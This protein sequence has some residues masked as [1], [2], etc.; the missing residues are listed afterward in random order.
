[1][2]EAGPVVLA[3]SGL[4]LLDSNQIREKTERGTISRYAELMAGGT[5]FP[6]IKVALTD[7]TDATK[8]YTLV[9][10]WHRVRAAQEIGL[11][12]IVAE[13]VTAQAHEVPWLAYEANRGHGLPLKLTRVERREIFRAY[14]QAKR[15][16]TG[17]G[18]AIKSANAM[19][20]DLVGIV[21][22]RSL[23]GWMASDF[24]AIYRA[25]N[26]GGLDP[27]EDQGGVKDRDMDAAYAKEARACLDNF[28]ACMR[29][30]RDNRRSLAILRKAVACVD[31][32][33]E[34]V[35]GKREWPKVT[36]DLF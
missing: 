29:S 1:M 20:K 23:P 5:A 32:V 11:G 30:L 8:G 12:T 26:M 33:S 19:A 7:P 27:Y 28:M 22:A 31:E 16:R 21:S 35:T 2:T 24:P 34:A 17:R 36:E 15:H 4:L 13:V 6:P 14:V 18:R 10:G 25:M 9:D 3:L